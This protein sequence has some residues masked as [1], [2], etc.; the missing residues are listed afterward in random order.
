MRRLWK[1]RR[2]A[3]G[4]HK[5]YLLVL[6]ATPLAFLFAEQI[7]DIHMELL[8]RELPLIAME[9]GGHLVPWIAG[10]Q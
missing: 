1:Y 3:T 10:V 6:S 7:A 2:V 5:A 9:T 8:Y 4:T